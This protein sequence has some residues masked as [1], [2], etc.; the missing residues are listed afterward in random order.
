MDGLENKFDLLHNFVN[1]TKLDLDI[2]CLSETGQK[3]NQDLDTNITLEG[4]KQPFSTGSK[5]NKGG[6][7]I[8][9]KDNNVFEREDLKKIDDCFE[10]IWVEIKNDKTKNIICGCNR[11]PNSDI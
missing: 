8:Y 5:F 9:T 6:V 1:N 3:L 10:A 11:H 7:A 4:Y 2:I